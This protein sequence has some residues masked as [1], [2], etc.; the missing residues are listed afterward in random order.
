MTMTVPTGFARLLATENITVRLDPGAPTASFDVVNRVLTMPN[1][2]ASDRLRDM[3]I[4]HEVGHALFSTNDLMESVARVGENFAIAKDYLNVVEDARI[5]RLI[6]RRYAGLRHDYAVGYREMLEKNFFGIDD[7]DP[8]TMTFIDRLNL[9]FK[10]FEGLQFSPDEQAFVDRM[11]RTETMDDAVDLARDIYEFAAASGEDQQ[12]TPSAGEGIEAPSSS[13]IDDDGMQG[14]QGEEGA[15]GEGSGGDESG[16]GDIAESPNG[17]SG[18]SGDGDGES[19]DADA[20]GQIGGR[21]GAKDHSP[22]APTTMRAMEN[23]VQNLADVNTTIQNCR[24]PKANL[25]SIVIPFTRILEE[26][27]RTGEAGIDK[28]FLDNSRPSV[29]NLAMLFERKKAAAIA[30]RTQVAKTGRLDMTALH[31]YKMTEDIF[32]RNRLEA[33]GK[34]HGMIVF[35]DWS[36]SM[37]DCMD[38]TIQ[39]TIV[40]AMFCRKVNIPFRVYGFTT[41]FKNRVSADAWTRGDAGATGIEDLYCGNFSLLEIFSDRM[42]KTDFDR[43][44]ACLLRSARGG[45]YHSTPNMMRLGGTPLNEA[46]IAGMDIAGAFRNENRVDVM[47]TVFITDGCGNAVMPGYGNAY[48]VNDPRNGATITLGSDAPER[49]NRRPARSE[50]LLKH[51]KAQIGGNLIGIYLDT[52]RNILRDIYYSSDDS[53][54]ITKMQESFKKNNFVQRSH[55]GYDTYFQMDKKIAVYNGSDSMDSLKADASVTKA[56]NAFKKDLGN[57]NAS[58][59]MLNEFTDRIAR[60]VV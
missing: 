8:H 58:R 40:L 53:V 24:I 4:G 5:D 26:Y 1:W 19:Q 30:Q 13:A 60:E 51:Y 49:H 48:V 32:L 17:S 12:E 16:E 20:G 45:M 27:G 23:A 46:I 39:Q 52:A 33:K 56:I 31:K 54:Q 18:G 15:E 2:S 3:L 44:A 37:N 43:M 14:E 50:W 59:P 6:Q 21:L 35:V 11:E 38:E 29:N 34:N 7:R 42:K 25:D 47:N 10:G 28:S 22:A 36:G 57:R 9:H 41:Y 55:D